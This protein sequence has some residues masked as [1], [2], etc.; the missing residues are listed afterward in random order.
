ERMAADRSK[1]AGINCTPPDHSVSLRARH[2][3]PGGPF[4]AEGLKERRIGREGG[5]LQVLDHKILGLVMDRH[6]VMFAALF[7]EPEPFPASVFVKITDLQKLWRQSLVKVLV[8]FNL[9]FMVSLEACSLARHYPSPLLPR[10]S[11]RVLR[12]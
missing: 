2:C 10:A 11:A 12:R 6:L 3:P 4:L 8:A 9:T 1:H 5:F 7:Q